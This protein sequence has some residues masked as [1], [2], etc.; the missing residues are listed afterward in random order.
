MNC[1]ADE[2]IWRPWS[3][4]VSTL[5]RERSRL[6]G[7]ERGEEIAVD[8]VAFRR[9]DEVVGGDICVA[10]LLLFAFAFAFASQQA[11]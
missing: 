11:I 2:S 10:T 5:A 1:K 9:S 7:G 4:A 3:Q 8:V 6:S